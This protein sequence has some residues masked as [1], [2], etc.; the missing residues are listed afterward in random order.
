MFWKYHSFLIVLELLPFINHVTFY[1]LVCFLALFCVFNL[2]VYLC[3][4]HHLNFY[5]F[6]IHS[7]VWASSATSSFTIVL[8]ILDNFDFFVN[9]KIS[10]SSF[11]FSCL[12][13][14]HTHTHTHTGSLIGI[15][16]TVL[17]SLYENWCYLSSESACQHL[18]YLFMSQ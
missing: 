5:S 7:N 6:I 14:I 15:T 8:L 4:N 17:V 13:Y 9:F 10:L 11:S 16:L 2:F 18:G 3:T 12:S 1:A